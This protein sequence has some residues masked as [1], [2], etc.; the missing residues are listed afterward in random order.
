[1]LT[2]K[3]AIEQR[4]SIRKFRPD[5]V[6]RDQINA[7]L[8]SA[9]LAPSACNAQP[10]RFKVVTD[11]ATRQ[12][13]AQAAFNQSFIAGAPVVFVC[14]VD[15]K[16]YLDGSV[17]RTQDLG[18]IKAVDEYVVEVVLDRINNVSKMNFE[19]IGVRIALNAA[20]AIE[21]I[22]LRALDFGL[23]TC[24]VRLFEEKKI[25]S[26]FGWG[27]NISVVSLLPAGYPAEFPP[28]RKR[29]SLD[30]ILTS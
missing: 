2:T 3:E 25:K 8:D 19:E 14:C 5:A 30:D 16:G 7:L 6:P 11:E 12:K 15:I 20:I 4:R 23:G 10:W 27:K 28:P 1:M 21:H 9:R 22:V 13:L 29:L 17:S 24:W 18:K 26:I